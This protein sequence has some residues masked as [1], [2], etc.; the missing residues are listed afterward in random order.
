MA[1]TKENYLKEIKEAELKCKAI[2][3]SM[4]ELKQ[5]LYSRFGNHIYLENDQDWV[6]LLLSIYFKIQDI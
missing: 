4:N 2:Q 3:E 1:K 6:L 5:N